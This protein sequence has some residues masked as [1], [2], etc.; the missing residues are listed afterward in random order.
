MDKENNN[1]VFHIFFFC[2][3]NHSVRESLH[4]RRLL[5]TKHNDNTSNAN[6]IDTKNST[7]GFG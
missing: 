1:E 4:L 7:V 6:N 3:N 2:P 5:V